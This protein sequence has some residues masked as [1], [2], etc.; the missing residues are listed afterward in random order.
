MPRLRLLV[1]ALASLALPASA[2]AE[3]PTP[4]APDQPAQQPPAAQQP[5]PAPQ[6]PPA[7]VPQPTQYPQQ[8]PQY[9]PQ[10]PQGDVQPGYPPQ[11]YPPPGYG[12]PPPGYGYGQPYGQPY[13]VPQGPPP[14][15][16]P[17]PANLRWSLRFDPFEL[18]MRRLT[19][20]AEIAIA[21]PFAIE[22]APSWI[23][24]SPYSGIDEKGFTIA[25]NAV[26]Y[27]SGQPFRG[28]WLK[29]HFAY[30]NFSATYA[31]PFDSTGAL[32]SAPKRFGSAI[33]G[34]MFGDT[35]VVPK[36]GGFAL[37]GGIGV[38]VATAGKATLNAPG[39][40]TRNIPGASATLYEGFDRVRI[41]GM[42]GL[43]VAF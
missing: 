7:Q 10:Y 30:E 35:F 21:G 4:P 25:G 19:F 24:G 29:A 38:G 40:P 17:K 20:Q 12:Q 3:T 6:Q 31:N 8:P 37:S 39:D 2:A 16:P 22:V 11:G 32:A 33:L 14:P 23:F 27:L 42:L 13:Y 36:S 41:L 9:P 26:F 43:G 1:W 15:P 18:L 5:P 34:A 28:L